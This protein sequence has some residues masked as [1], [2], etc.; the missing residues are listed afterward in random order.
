MED[1]TQEIRPNFAA[2]AFNGVRL[3]MIGDEIRDNEQAIQRLNDAW[4]ADH[5]RRVDDWLDRLEEQD[6]EVQQ[7][8]PERQQ[9][10]P[11]REVQPARREQQQD[12]RDRRPHNEENGG[13]QREGDQK[14]T[15]IGDFDES[16]APPNVI[17]PRPSS[18][19]IQKIKVYE[20]VELWYFSLEG[21]LEAS[22]SSR[23]QADDTLGITTAHDVL[24]VRPIAAVKA[25]RNARADH[26]LSFGSFLH[27]K[28]VYIQQISQNGW[29]KKHVD[30]LAKFF[31]FVENHQLRHT[32]ENGNLILLHYASCTRR[33]WHDDLKADTGKVFNIALINETLMNAISH[34]INS[35]FQASATRRSVPLF[36]SFTHSLILFF[37]FPPLPPPVNASPPPLPLPLPLPP[38]TLPFDSTTGAAASPHPQHPQARSLHGGPCHP[39]FLPQPTPSP[40]PIPACRA[41]PFSAPQLPLPLPPAGLIS[42]TTQPAGKRAGIPPVLQPPRDSG[43]ELHHRH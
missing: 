19:A 33:R 9:D 22:H 31:F 13:N 8:R 14:K 2:A 24:T 38:T 4:E 6:E 7:P 34:E 32:G 15:Q 18:Y 37:S 11:D 21:C 30:A 20:Y 3:A 5:R 17:A 26:E 43:Q 1:P 16:Q 42:A 41:Q 12:D 40:L 10:E 28:N 35:S 27:A 39:L 23:S 29:P 36:P 25:S